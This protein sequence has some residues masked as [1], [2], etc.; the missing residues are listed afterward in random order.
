MFGYATDETPECM[1]LTILLAHRLAQKMGD[2]RRSPE[3]AADF[4]LPDAKT[5]VTVE[6]KMI[7]GRT[8]PLRVHT[9]VISTQHTAEISCEDLRK[10]LKTA[11]IDLVIPKHLLDDKTVYHIQ[12]SGTFLIGGPQGDAGLTGRKIIVDTYG[13][14][15]AHG[16]GA[17]SGKDWSKVDRSAAYAARWI[18]KSLVQARLASRCLIQISYAI[19][20]SQ[21]LSLFID[22]FGTGRHPD[23]LLLSLVKENFDL[24]PGAIVKELKLMEPKF[25]ETA[26]YGHFGR[27]EF[28]W[29]QAKLLKTE[30][31]LKYMLSRN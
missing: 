8:V 26:C 1:P 21:P 9:V 11:V 17:F 31:P 5:Q 15:G 29:E 30:G 13:G 20:V 28:T 3:A 2:L 18:A 27:E 14:W 7:A 16:G 22:T 25:E 10:F 6:Y 12:P 19:G 24:R 23:H 4:L